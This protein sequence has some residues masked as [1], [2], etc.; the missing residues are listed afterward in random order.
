MSN[1]ELI[2]DYLSNR[3]TGA[4]KEAFEKQLNND[5][6]LKSDLDFQKRIVEGIRTARATELKSML[7][8]VPVGGAS[9]S[10]DFSV[11]KSSVVS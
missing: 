9:A 8:K 3:L 2:D 7:S 5:P 10:M 11:M 1:F 6:S 4:E